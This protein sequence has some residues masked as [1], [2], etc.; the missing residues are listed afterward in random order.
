[1]I[2]NMQ[3][4][5]EPLHSKD[6]FLTKITLAQPEKNTPT[7][8]ILNFLINR[9]KHEKRKSLLT[10]DNDIVITRIN[11]N[12]EIINRRKNPLRQKH[13]DQR[14]NFLGQENERH[15]KHSNRT[16]EN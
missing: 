3:N 12:G 16:P 7:N 13:R 2:P 14:A 8:A 11:D 5:Q 1:M 6:M 15:H 10:H 4:A 9:N